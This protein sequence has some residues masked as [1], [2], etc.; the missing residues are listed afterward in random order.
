[1]FEAYV[2]DDRLKARSVV[3]PA[4]DK[5]KV[6]RN[7]EKQLRKKVIEALR[8]PSAKVSIDILHLQLLQLKMQRRNRVL[9]ISRCFAENLSFTY[10]CY[11]D[12]YIEFVLIS[13]QNFI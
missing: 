1:V 9:L 5:G 7:R 3:D 2:R 12:L 4:C 11:V 8:D 10:L 13:L 6:V